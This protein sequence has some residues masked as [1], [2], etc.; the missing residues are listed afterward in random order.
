M[1]RPE[2]ER[3]ACGVGFIAHLR[4]E[5]SHGIIENALSI[6]ENLEH[7]GAE[8]SDP[9]T[10]DGAG[11]LMQVPHALFVAEAER[12]KIDLPRRAGVYGVGM[13][14]LPADPKLCAAAVALIE[15]IIASERQHLLGWREVPIDSSAAGAAARASM[16]TI[17][18]FFVGPGTLPADH[19]ALGRK[20]YVIR[21]RIDHEARARGLREGD[22]PYVCSLSRSTIVYKGLLTPEQLPRFYRDLSDPRMKSALS[23]VHQRFSTNTFPSWSRAHPYRRIAHN[24]EINT[25]RG[26]V[27]WMLAREPVL[28]SPLFGED[29]EKLRPF[30]DPDG[31]D[32]AMF[33]DVLEL[34][35]HTGRS[36]SHAIMMMIPEAWQK[37]HAMDP[38]RRAFYEYHSCVMEPWDGPACIA[39]T[40]GTRVGA[41]LDRNGLRPARYTITKD[42]FVIMASEAGVLPVAPDNVRAHDRLTPGKMFLVDTHLGTIVDDDIIKEEEATRRPWRRWLDESIVTMG[43]MPPAPRDSIPPPPSDEALCRR[44]RA[45]GYTTEDLRVLMTPMGRDGREPT[46]SMGN[47]TPLAV[48][49]ES[50]QL[51]F[52][53]FKQLFA[54]V[55]N[56]PIDPIREAFV[57]TLRTTLG[58]ENNLFEESPLHCQKLQLHSA[59]PHRDRAGAD[60]RA[61]S[62]RAS[63]VHARRRLRC[64]SGRGPRGRARTRSA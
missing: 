8:G 31:S 42:D 56:P 28:R 38:D 54:Q 44:Q 29:V 34:L 1:Y 13:V 36:L 39:F 24:G 20:E 41:V 9:N 45:F 55:T 26:N 17:R 12:L 10:G 60:P 15:E 3:D 27:N 62:P 30:V 57:M 7:R 40:D 18:Q 11:L 19:A 59:D 63:R 61:R 51:V 64:R 33:D 32:S 5:P 48:L 21:K 25:L 16:P 37:H 50:P 35:D 53:Y 22:Y 23:I 49:S 2:R 52:A 14:F 47:D 58:P 6:L 43:E 4:G 46:G